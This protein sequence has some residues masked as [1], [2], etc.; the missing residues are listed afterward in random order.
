MLT[1]VYDPSKIAEN[2]KDRMRFE[3]G[4]TMV[5]GAAETCALCDEEYEAALALYPN[6]WRR[7]KLALLESIV[8]RFFY[9]VDTK[10]GPLSLSLRQR[11]EA[12]K[13]MYDELKEECA[14][15][16]APS[17]N[18]KALARPPYFYEGMHDNRELGGTG[19]GGKRGGRFV[20]P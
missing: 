13:L 7:A 3:L 20:L 11:A 9:E 5:E 10:V 8:H 14:M 4:D 16:S 17:A 15:L 18:P 19:K 6:S 2:G 12:W 1:Y